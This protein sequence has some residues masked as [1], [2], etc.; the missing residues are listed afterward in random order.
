MSISD[1]T[2]ERQEPNSN[3]RSPLRVRICSRRSPPSTSSRTK[4]AKHELHTAA[5]IIILIRTDVAVVLLVENF[6]QFTDIRMLQV[7][8]NADLPC[9]GGSPRIG[10]MG[11]LS[12]R[13]D[14]LVMYHLDRIPFTCG[15]GDGFHNGC[16]RAFAEF[17]AQVVVGIKARSG[18]TSGGVTVDKTYDRVK[19]GYI[20][21]TPQCSR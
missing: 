13:P 9:K 16:K 1:Y 5:T 8:H 21:K 4:P 18:R 20:G 19:M 7:L 17:R 2:E 15:T 6:F 12:G 14:T 3:L 10:A 11:L